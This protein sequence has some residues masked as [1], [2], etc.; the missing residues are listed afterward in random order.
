MDQDYSAEEA[1]Q[2]AVR[3][4]GTGS[5]VEQLEDGFIVWRPPAPATSASTSEGMSLPSR[6][7]I[8]KGATRREALESARRAVHR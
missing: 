5:L 6:E 1:D 3:L 7:A 4:F 2:L 8:G